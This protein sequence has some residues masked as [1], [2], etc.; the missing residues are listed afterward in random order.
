GLPISSAYGGEKEEWGWAKSGAFE[1]W[2]SKQYK[3]TQPRQ[4]EIESGVWAWLA[5]PEAMNM[6]DE[7]I[8]QEI[9]SAGFDP[10]DFGYY[11]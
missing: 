1:E 8:K 3:Q 5:S 2:K 10:N 7:Q 4:F 6:S 11:Q 9:M